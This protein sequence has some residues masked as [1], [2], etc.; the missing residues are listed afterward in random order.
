MD[1]QA[2]TEKEATEDDQKIEGQKKDKKRSE[3][4]RTEKTF[5]CADLIRH[6]G[7]VMLLWL[8]VSIALAVHSD[9]EKL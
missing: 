5:V 8:V 7:S 1:L 9:R 2:S 4:K 3:K 6:D